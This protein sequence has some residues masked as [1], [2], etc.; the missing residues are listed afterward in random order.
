MSWDNETPGP[1]G[2][3]LDWQEEAARRIEVLEASVRLFEKHDE[4]LNQR[5]GE[6]ESKVSELLELV[7]GVIG[8]FAKWAAQ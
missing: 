6:L 3:N 1:R 7:G 5:V 8:A 4:D 2:A